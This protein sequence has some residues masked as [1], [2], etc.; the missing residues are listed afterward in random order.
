[1]TTLAGPAGA[2]SHATTTSIKQQEAVQRS[3]YGRASMRAGGSA[4][5]PTSN[6]LAV[7]AGVFFKRLL[8]VP[9]DEIV[10][11]RKAFAPA[12]LRVR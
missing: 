5:V 2:F 6:D 8:E 4:C 11:F 1:M 7:P 12:G 3:A 10:L 9:G